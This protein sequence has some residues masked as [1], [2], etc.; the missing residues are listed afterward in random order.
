MVDI[1]TH[2]AGEAGVVLGRAVAAARRAGELEA[3]PEAVRQL[4]T[5]QGGAA[6]WVLA[7]GFLVGMEE[8]TGELA[9]VLQSA[10]SVTGASSDLA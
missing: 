5:G 6:R 3:E 1:S 8:E 10:A 4:L 2:D 9:E 7:A